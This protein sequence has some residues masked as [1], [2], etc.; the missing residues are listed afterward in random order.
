MNTAILLP[1]A[2]IVLSNLFYNICTKSSPENLD[3]FASLTVTYLVGA[4]FSGVLFFVTNRGGNLLDA[5]KNVNW[6]TWILG[7][8]IVGLEAGYLALYKAGG[9]ISTSQLVCSAL[10]EIC[11]LV[12]G[13]VF[14]KEQLSFSKIAGVI[15]CLAGL[16]LIS[17]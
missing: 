10:L 6:S 3:P 11:L 17:R 5:Y 16:G 4:L 12:V 9:Q 2:V 14:F 13:L 8:S 15:V 7:L 1:V